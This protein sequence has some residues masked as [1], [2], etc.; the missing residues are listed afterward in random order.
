MKGIAT[1]CGSVRFREAFDMVNESLTLAGWVVL[2]PGVWRHDELHNNKPES[3]EMKGMLDKLHNEKI[4]MSDSIVVVN[5]GDYVGEST[6]REV[7]FAKLH[8]KKIYWVNPM[9]HSKEISW[10]EML[11]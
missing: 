11:K 5:V 6:I 8:D 9:K 10:R 7:M 1:L 4:L 3:A 2:Q